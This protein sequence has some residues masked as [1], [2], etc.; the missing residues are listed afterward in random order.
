MVSF[1]FLFEPLSCYQPC[2]RTVFQVGKHGQL[3]GGKRRWERFF[4]LCDIRWCSQRSSQ[5]Y[6]EEEQ[7]N[8]LCRALVVVLTVE[9]NDNVVMEVEFVSS[10]LRVHV[11]FVTIAV[12]TKPNQPAS[13]PTEPSSVVIEAGVPG[14][15]DLRFLS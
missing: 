4:L 6:L 5:N 14:R 7:N 2:I 8:I 9:L 11:R 12:A 13:Q 1:L 10:S 15:I 3:G